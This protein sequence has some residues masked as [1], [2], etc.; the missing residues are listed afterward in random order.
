M[1]NTY[2]FLLYLG[3][4]LFVLSSNCFELDIGKTF[5]YNKENV[6]INVYKD[7]SD[8]FYKHKPVKPFLL[9]ELYYL[10]KLI[11][12]DPL[13]TSDQLLISA[14]VLW[15][16]NNPTVIHLNLEKSTIILLNE[17]NSSLSVE[18]IFSGKNISNINHKFHPGSDKAVDVDIKQTQNYTSNSLNVSVNQLHLSGNGLEK[19]VLRYYD[20]G[21][22]KLNNLKYGNDGVYGYGILTTHVK[23]D[24]V[25]GNYENKDNNFPL[26]VPNKEQVYGVYVYSY[27]DF[28]LII[29]LVYTYNKRLYFAFTFEKRYHRILMPPLNDPLY[30][31]KLFESLNYYTCKNGFKT[32]IDIAKVTNDPNYR[33]TLEFHCKG[34][35]GV[36]T[37]NK[38][39]ILSFYTHS[40]KKYRC[41]EHW[42]SDK[43]KFY[44][45]Q[46]YSGQS[47]VEFPPLPQHIKFVR[48]YHQINKRPYLVVFISPNDKLTFYAYKNGA[49][50][51][52]KSS[53]LLKISH[54]DKYN[55]SIVKLLDA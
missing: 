9:K 2:T 26:N 6:E 54:S 31:K 46:I 42:T 19:F 1:K 47:I 3:F 55:Y 14:S 7:D 29:D 51:Q 33:Y 40:N 32:S 11:Y 53:Q 20:L 38:T 22:Y 34:P 4:R 37:F 25:P 36:E 45:D 16:S 21:S 12:F 48:V 50:H 23:D 35:N 28:P 15:V 27:N 43:S 24:A 41:Y 17:N 44:M 30:E 49:W 5:S 52:D 8:N 39:F 13:L 18:A 10:D